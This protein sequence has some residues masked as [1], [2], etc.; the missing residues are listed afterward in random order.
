MTIEELKKRSQQE[1]D[2]YDGTSLGQSPPD[3][4]RIILQLIERV[5][6]LSECLSSIDAWVNYDYE[7]SDWIAKKIKPAIS[8]F[9]AEVPL[10]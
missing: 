3:S 4:A 7:G 5:E 1:I 6:K 10:V 8:E 2:R 9:G